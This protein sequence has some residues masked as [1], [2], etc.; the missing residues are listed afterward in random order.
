[1]YGQNHT[2][3]SRMQ[4]NKIYILECE[5]ELPDRYANGSYTILLMART[6]TG[7]RFI[8]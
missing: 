4:I 3:N 8:L 5:E 7:H 6:K 2:N 1:M